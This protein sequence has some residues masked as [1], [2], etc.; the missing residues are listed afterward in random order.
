MERGKLQINLSS[1]FVW[2]STREELSTSEQSTGQTG[3]GGGVVTVLALEFRWLYNVGADTGRQARIHQRVVSTKR[4]GRESPRWNSDAVASGKLQRRRDGE[5]QFRGGLKETSTR[6][7]RAVQARMTSLL[8][9][10]RVTLS[11]ARISW[12]AQTTTRDTAIASRTCAAQCDYK[13][14]HD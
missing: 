14:W 2:S 7:L 1:T 11:V 12:K 9:G 4:H 8:C 3:S 6:H 5:L 10:G 13:Q